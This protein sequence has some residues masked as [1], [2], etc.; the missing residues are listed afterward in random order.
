LD[1]RYE[2]GWPVVYITLG[3]PALLALLSIFLV[4]INHEFDT[5]SGVPYFLAIVVGSDLTKLIRCLLLE[6]DA[7]VLRGKKP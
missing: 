4:A 2:W 5:I 6:R 1:T 7:K 3:L